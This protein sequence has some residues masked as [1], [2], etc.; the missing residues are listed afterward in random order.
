MKLKRFKNGGVHPDPMKLTAGKPIVGAPCPRK[1]TL[2]LSQHIGAP[3]KCIVKVGEK[4]EEGQMVAEAGGFVSAPVHT[5]IAGVVKKIDLVRD[6]QGLWKEAILIEEEPSEEP[7]KSQT[8]GFDQKNPLRSDDQ[9]EKLSGKEIVDIIAEAGIVGLGGAA[10]P[11]RVKLT[12]PPGKKADVFLINGAECEPYLTCDDALMRA[13][14]GEIVRGIRYLMK[15]SGTSKAMIG[16]E[17][18][19]PEAIEALEMVTMSSPDIE[20]VPLRTAYPQGGEKQLIQALTGRAV[21]A[22]GLPIDAG[23]IVDNVATAFAVYRAVKFGEPLV[24]RVATV[25]GVDVKDA[26]NFIVAV[27]TDMNSVLE[28]AGGIPEETGKIISGGPMMG[29]AVSQPDAPLM[30]ANGGFVL[31]PKTDTARGEVAPCVR[32]CKCVDACPMNLQPYLLQI[33]AEYELPDD[34]KENG[35]L[36]CMECGCCSFICPSNRPI[37]D[38]I[39]LSKLQLR[40]KG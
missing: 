18:N 21:P 2:F 23:V 17:A 30:K 25:T 37:V 13:Y 34:A 1:V 32:C 5:P 38:F 29:R 7:K 28:L 16:I 36:N 27:G 3:A 39:K 31:M 20:V 4:V 14:P 10:F 12:L 15:A 19:K 24:K 33:L 8:L 9:I 40:K 35:V 11:T 6:S 26:G 22:G